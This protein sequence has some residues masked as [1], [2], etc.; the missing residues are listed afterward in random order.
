MEAEK[1][2]WPDPEVWVAGF[3]RFLENERGYSDMTVRNYY[4]ALAEFSRTRNV[5]RWKDAQADDF[6][7]YLYE[8]SVRR[9]LGSSTVRLH[10][11]ALRSFY[12]YLVKQRHLEASP[13]GELSL[14][15]PKKKLP[16]IFNET[17]I[18]A[19]LDAPL[20]MLRDL[21]RKDAPKKRGRP[22]A[23]WQFL[24]DAAVLEFL[25]STGIR[26]QEL[27]GMD[28]YDIDRRSL[29]VRVIGKGSK[30][31]MVILGEPALEAYERYR[32]AMTGCPVPAFIGSGDKRLT[33]RTVQLRF[34]VYLE[35]AG[36]D[37]SLTP[38]KLRHSFA[39][40][41]LDHGADL[42]NVQELLGHANLSTTQIY[43]QLTA[44]RM[45]KSYDQAHP[46]AR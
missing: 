39:T 37:S 9:G 2:S 35:Y 1:I 29:A 3:V 43:A 41:M 6:R 17:Q 46:A 19:F 8:L 21:Q 12:R 22:M 38:H 27:V 20:S 7:A 23:P 10:F 36:L 44:E 30:E 18:N 14:P 31:R 4:H 24:R 45:R 5:K 42:R 40:H 16:R 11:S 33:A 26:I 28:H 32:A 13:L 15:S 25:Y 34:K